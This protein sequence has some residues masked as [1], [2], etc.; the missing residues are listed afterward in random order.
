MGA[1]EAIQVL[2]ARDGYISSA[3]LAQYLGVS[4]RTAQRYIKQL[5]SEGR[6]SPDP[7]ARLTCISAAVA[8]RGKRAQLV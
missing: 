7:K 8:R 3:N 1:I 6:L 5:V 4:L 2:F